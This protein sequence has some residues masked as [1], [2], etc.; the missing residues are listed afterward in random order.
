MSNQQYTLGDRVKVSRPPT[1]GRPS[2]L[3]KLTGTIVYTNEHFFSVR[4][5]RHGYRESFLWKD[6]V[7]GAIVVQIRMPDVIYLDNVKER[8]MPGG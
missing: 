1:Q 7:S 4:H 6:I 3:D 8:R 5:D 2:G